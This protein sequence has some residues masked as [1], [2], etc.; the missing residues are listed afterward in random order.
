MLLAGLATTPPA[1]GQAGTQPTQSPKPEALLLIVDFSGSMLE[2]D[3][4]GST[5]LAAAKQ[6]LATIIPALPDDLD[7]GLRV[8]GHRVP[9]QDKAAACQDTE[10]VVPIGPLDKGALNA[11]VQGLDALGETPIGLSLQKAAEACRRTSRARSSW[12]RTE[13]TSASR[14]WARTRAR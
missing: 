11:T 7:V 14:I 4:S 1:V 9:S 13:R 2:P 12:S 10:L 8:Y 6:A 5:R 3:G